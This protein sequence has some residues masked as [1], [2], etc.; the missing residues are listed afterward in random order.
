M[1]T[2][3]AL[4]FVFSPFLQVVESFFTSLY[5]LT[6]LSSL[7]STFYSPLS[8]VYSSLLPTLYATL[9]AL[10]L[11]FLSFTLLFS[12]SHNA[13]KGTHW[14]GDKHTDRLFVYT[15]AA[16]RGMRSLEDV[17]MTTYNIGQWTALHWSVMFLKLFLFQPCKW[18]YALSVSVKPLITLCACLYLCLCVSA[19][20]FRSV[21]KEDKVQKRRKETNR[22]KVSLASL[23]VIH[24][25]LLTLTLILFRFWFFDRTNGMG[26]RCSRCGRSHSTFSRPSLLSPLCTGQNYS[27]QTS[28]GHKRKSNKGKCISDWYWKVRR[29]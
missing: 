27:Q 26:R 9:S 28:T 12:L 18:F 5:V 14:I 13:L 25:Y 23:C 20:S 16:I 21:K 10:Q 17:Q 15:L 1:K 6:F 3:S 11:S 2:C 24:C 7:L 8:T 22:H 29:W 4:P 19:L